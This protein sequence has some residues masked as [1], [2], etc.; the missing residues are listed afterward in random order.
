MRRALALAAA[1]AAL[2]A[3]SLAAAQAPPA[4]FVQAGRLLA[5]PATGVV[6]AQKTLVIRG[7]K[8]E[9]IRDGFVGEPG[10]QVIDLRDA[11][12]LPGLID[13]HVHLLHENGPND[14]LNR[15]AKTPADL[16]LDGVPFAR[17]TL[18]AGFTTVANLGDE[19]DSIFALR[20]AIAA[21]RIDGPRVVAGGNV[22][23]PPGGEGD[24]HGYR[25]DVM[26]LLARPNLCTGAD[27]CAR[28]V[29]RHVQ[30]GGDI[31]KIVATGAVLSDAATGL[32]QQFTDVEMKAIVDTA[33]A[34]GRKVAAH[35]HSAAG[36]NAALRAGVDSIEHGTF[37]DVE[38]IRLF[39]ASGAYLVPTLL[40]GDT[41][42]AWALDPTSHLGARSREKARFVGPK[43]LDAARRAHAGGVRI[44]FGTDS[45]VSKHGQ[46]AREF[47]LLVRAGLTPLQAIQSA[48]ING[49]EHLG[50]ASEIG[51]LKPGK[52]ADLIAVAGDPLRDVTELERVRFVMKAGSPY[53]P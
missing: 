18:A 4:T 12:V 32:D 1:V 30:R 23:S 19:N 45:S 16:A 27:E 44:A 7:G 24:L 28:V 35:A 52:A 14:R 36:I 25:P 42:T 5:D 40:A 53:G 6:T 33:H 43:M 2:F 10:G 37:L 39:K 48:T 26:A 51:S 21:G 29:R 50:L 34:L 49:A 9:A 11:F 47:G 13:S 17:A 3:P 20:D 31:I 8:V 38:S 15:V 22:I 46:N 41:V